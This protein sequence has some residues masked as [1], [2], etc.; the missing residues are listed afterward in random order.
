MCLCVI[1]IIFAHAY[2][3]G[4]RKSQYGVHLKK[5]NCFNIFMAKYL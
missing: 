5:A 3:V 2:T 1:Q 4:C